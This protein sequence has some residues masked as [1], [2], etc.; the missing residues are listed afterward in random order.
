MTMH[1]WILGAT[2]AVGCTPSEE[3]KRVQLEV[4]VDDAALMAGDNDLGWRVEL[5]AARLA[6]S[7]L[8][9]TI[10]GEMHQASAWLPSWVI[11]RAWAHPGHLAG[12]DVTGELTGEFVL[13]WV[14]G[15]GQR[16]GAAELLT[17]VYQGLNFGF[18]A[19]A[20]S[21]GLS[22]DDPLL[23]HS[24]YFA[25]TASK[26]GQTIT[27]TAQIDVDA[28]TQMVGAIFDLEVERTDQ[29]LIAIQLV[30]VDPIEGF[31]LFDGLDFAALDLDGDGVVTIVPGD[32]AHNFVRRTVQSH[33]H[34]GAVDR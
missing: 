27:F 10:L 17:G 2:L 18:R 28:G 14:A 34:Y 32:E 16:L 29:A 20:A 7:D 30:P 24:A 8:Q 33:V 3:A 23:G 22:A 31:S 26:A 13:D 1:R 5:G 21:D 9:F 6:V 25:G 15:G 12:G 19:A 4:E 11:G